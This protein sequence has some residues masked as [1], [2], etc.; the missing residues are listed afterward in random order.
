MQFHFYT[1][2]II[3]LTWS[4]KATTIEK[5]ETNISG[6]THFS[7]HL[8]KSILLIFFSNLLQMCWL[9]HLTDVSGDFCLFNKKTMNYSKLMFDLLNLC[10]YVLVSSMLIVIL[11]R[12]S[13]MAFHLSLLSMHLS[14]FPNYPIFRC[15]STGNRLPSKQ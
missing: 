5:K 14:H 6:G 7:V 11:V 4:L 1:P 2:F 10:V 9:C 15:C 13:L 3:T 8:Y 12:F